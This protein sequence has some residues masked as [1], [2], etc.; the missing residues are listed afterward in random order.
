MRKS[1]IIVN[2]FLAQLLTTES[3]AEQISKHLDSLKSQSKKQSSLLEN[4]LKS[5]QSENKSAST[6]SRTG[7]YKGPESIKPDKK[8]IHLKSMYEE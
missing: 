4:V 8:T 5:T 2:G 7:F 6:I 1:L 3:Q